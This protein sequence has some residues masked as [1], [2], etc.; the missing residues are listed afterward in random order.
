MSVDWRLILTALLSTVLLAWLAAA[1]ARRLAAGT[2]R[3]ALGDA[4]SPVSSAIRAPLRVV[5]ITTLMLVAA[6]LVFPALS[7]TGLRPLVGRDGGAIAAWLLGSGLRIVLIVLVAYILC[8]ATGMVVRRFEFEVSRGTTRDA[9][10]RAKR[11]RT[12]GFVVSKTI[13]G[14]VIGAAGV[15]ILSEVGVN[16]GPLLAGAG[17]AGVAV[18]FGAQ[19]L[20]RDIISGFFLILEDQVRVGDMSAINGTSGMVED[21]NLRTIVLRDV[22]GTVHVFPNGA[23]NTLANLSKEYSRYLIDLNISFDE[24]PDRI[25]DIVRDVDSGLRSDPQ[26]APLILAPVEVLGISGFSDWAMQLRMRIKTLPLQQGV[27]GREFRKR[28]MKALNRH[29]IAV[30]LP[31]Y[32]TRSG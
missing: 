30:P 5:F 14:L 28:L 32:R 10:E 17:I 12:L 18:G 31:A 21:L 11:A 7:L 25:S 1:L 16:I 29:G 24:D 15:M 22:R 27:V 26:F 6:L 8:R 3:A 13:T 4:A 9:L 20:V 23:I 2:F 19:T